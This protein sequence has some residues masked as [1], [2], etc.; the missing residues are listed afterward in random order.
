MLGE[1]GSVQVMELGKSGE[2]DRD[3]PIQTII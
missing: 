3:S 2:F 1:K